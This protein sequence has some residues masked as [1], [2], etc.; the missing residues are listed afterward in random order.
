MYIV[1]RMQLPDRFTLGSELTNR[2]RRPYASVA[3][4]VQ[5]SSR[6]GGWPSPRRDSAR[7]LAGLMEEY[8]ELEETFAPEVLTLRSNW[9]T[10]RR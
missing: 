3:G 5:L 1:Y 4:A 9:I 10:D 7:T 2:L 8:G 6:A